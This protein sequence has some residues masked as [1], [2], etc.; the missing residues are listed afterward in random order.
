M[1]DQEIEIRAAGLWA[2][3]KLIDSGYLGEAPGVMPARS[4]VVYSQNDPKWANVPYAREGGLTFAKAGCLVTCITMIAS[5]AYDDPP[6]PTEVAAKLA[7]AGAFV[8]DLLSNPSKIGE[9]LPAL[10]WAGVLHWRDHPADIEALERELR[11]YRATIAEV[12]W[13]PSKP[14]VTGD[15]WNQHFITVTRF[16]EDADCIIADPWDGQTKQLSAS[17]Y[18]CGSVQKTLYGL[19]LVRVR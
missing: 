18:W 5:L 9:A 14:L 12:K 11:S 17:R 7:K 4:L 1:P 8:G 15:K 19:R 2:K 3:Y 16:T 13:D 10:E 6:K